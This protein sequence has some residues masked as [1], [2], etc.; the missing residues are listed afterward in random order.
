MFCI[1]EATVWLAF[2]SVATRDDKFWC[3]LLLF[4]LVAFWHS[5]FQVY[6]MDATV[7]GK[8][9]VVTESMRLEADVEIQTIVVSLF[10]F[11]S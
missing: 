11:S 8:R 10:F 3:N 9:G 4:L 5:G 6:V 2:V 1:N 7:T